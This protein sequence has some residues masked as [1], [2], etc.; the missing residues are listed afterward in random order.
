MS[1][2]WLTYL[3]HLHSNMMIEFNLSKFPVFCGLVACR[4]LDTA[5]DPLS[6]GKVADIKV[7]SPAA[8]ASDRDAATSLYKWQVTGRA[9]LADEQPTLL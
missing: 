2:E 6:C 3:V 8:V 5:R 9:T 7:Q 1:Y 4:A